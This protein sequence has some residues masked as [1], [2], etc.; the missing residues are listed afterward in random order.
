MSMLQQHAH[1]IPP[2]KKKKRRRKELS[3]VHSLNKFYSLRTGRSSGFL[4][5]FVRI[6][7]SQSKGHGLGAA[8][9]NVLTP[10]R[11]LFLLE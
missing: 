1:Y 11:F 9:E 8:M 4:K 6:M 3:L 7:L 10:K 2:Q 5:K